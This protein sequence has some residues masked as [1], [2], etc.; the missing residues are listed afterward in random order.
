VPD[1]KKRAWLK[2]IG[3]ETPKTAI[4]TQNPGIDT[5]REQKY[6]LDG[7]QTPKPEHGEID[8]WIPLIFWFNTDPRLAIPSVSIP[9]GQRFIRILFASADEIASGVDFGGGGAIIPPTI[10]LLELYINNIF[11]N[12]EIHDVFIKRVGFYLIR[13]H[14]LERKPLTANANSILL[15]QLKWPIETVYFG[16]RP[17][18][19]DSSMTDWHKFHLTVDT[20][21]TYPVR[22]P[23]TVFPFIPP[24][25]LAFADAT[26]QVQIPTIK[27]VAWLT[28]GIEL[29]H[30][31][32]A[33][34]FN[35]YIPL[36]YGGK[37]I[38]TPD[39]DIGMF[40]TTF[41]LY[42]GTYQP[43]GHINLSTTREF[44]FKYTSDVISLSVPCTLVVIG[45]AINFLLITG[46]TAVLRYNT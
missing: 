38:M 5:V 18:I 39:N 13:V 34:F 43:S 36:N 4:L 42:P 10:S 6:I 23:N 8:L 26:Y 35:I 44:Y 28:H 9:Y 21:V 3:Q 33:E 20:A 30:E 15:D 1:W 45:I 40:M 14:R 41:N 12:P 7:P 32:V 27:T 37:N 29:Y 31:T 2:G 19:N 16:V 11:V 22:I 24:D 46:G 17:N 25:Q